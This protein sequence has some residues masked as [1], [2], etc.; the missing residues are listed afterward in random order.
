LIDSGLYESEEEAARRKE[1]L[2]RIDKVIDCFRCFSHYLFEEKKCVR[3]VYIGYGDWRPFSALVNALIVKKFSFCWPCE[4]QTVVLC[5][6]R[7]IADRNNGRNTRTKLFLF[8][9]WW[10]YML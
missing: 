10:I 3:D 9:L 4:F 6:S 1:V 7:E 8:S 5:E 2:G